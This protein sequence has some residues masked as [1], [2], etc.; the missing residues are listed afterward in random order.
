MFQM[1]NVF[2]CGEELHVEFHEKSLERKKRYGRQQASFYKESA[3]LHIPIV[4]KLKNVLGHGSR[5]PDLE[6]L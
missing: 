4:I 3:V 5:V 1:L 2:K 6:F